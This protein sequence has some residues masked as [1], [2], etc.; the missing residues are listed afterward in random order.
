MSLMVGAAY[1]GIVNNHMYCGNNS[2]SME[3]EYGYI[4][5]GLFVL[6]YCTFIHDYYK[7]NGIDK[8]LFLSR[9]GDIINRCII[10]CI[11][12]ILRNMRIG[13]EKR[14]QS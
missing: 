5:G 11:R 2:Y 8:I 4:Y 6:G 14:L 13:R 1:R 10:S 7:K 9:D 3:Y 12:K